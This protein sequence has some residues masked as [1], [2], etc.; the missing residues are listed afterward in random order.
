MKIERRSLK[1]TKFAL[2]AKYFC[3]HAHSTDMIGPFGHIR[4][5][6]IGEEK[7]HAVDIFAAQMNRNEKKDKTVTS[8]PTQRIRFWTLL[9][10]FSS[11]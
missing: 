1:K 6:N 4:S 3:R 2:I 8:I 5:A 7:S 9:A 10:S 11:G